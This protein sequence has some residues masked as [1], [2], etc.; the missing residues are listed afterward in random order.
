RLNVSDVVTGPSSHVRLTNTATQPV[1]AW[2]LAATTAS[3][4]G[5]THREVYTSDG[6]LSEVTHGL[7]GA[8]ARLER[9]M[10]GE[11][12]QVALDPLQPGAMVDLIAAVLDDGTAFGD[13]EAI[14]AI[15]AHRVKERDALPA[16][17]GRALHRRAPRPPRRRRAHRPPR[18]VL[19]ARA[20]RRFGPLPRRA[21]RG[22]GV[23]TEVRRRR[24]RQ[25][26]PHLRCLRAEG[27]RGR[28]EARRAAWHSN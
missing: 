22:A 2:S 27:V 16:A 13:E 28:P 11:S 24:D 20:T 1:T 21:R 19:G 17:G 6:Y 10:P 25:F 3:D 26:A 18:A 8:N 4:S 23:S 12:R 14:A 9:I 15:F 7:P 5:R